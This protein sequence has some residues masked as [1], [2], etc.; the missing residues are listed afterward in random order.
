ME[1]EFEEKLNV[2]QKGVLFVNEITKVRDDT[3][4]SIIY[5]GQGARYRITSKKSLLA[6]GSLCKIKLCKDVQND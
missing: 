3:G 6:S 4:N 1:K 5:G 2:N